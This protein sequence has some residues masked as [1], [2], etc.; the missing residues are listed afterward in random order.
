MKQIILLLIT[1]LTLS[2]MSCNED[3]E[4]GTAQIIDY[5][6]LKSYPFYQTYEIEYGNYL[7]NF[8]TVQLIMDIYDKDVHEL[9]LYFQPSCS[10]TGTK[11]LFPQFQKVVD[12][13]GIEN[14]LWYAMKTD[15]DANPNDYM[16][17]IKE[18]PAFFVLKNGV[19]VY[20]IVDT[21]NARVASGSGE[22]ITLEALL[23]EALQK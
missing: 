11:V 8:D 2:S 23:Y 12:D 20:S 14:Y 16:F 3:V 13:A 21:L 1:A 18:L 15:E 17:T 19:A 22:N 7:P 4:P 9:Y 10:C 5:E 6:E